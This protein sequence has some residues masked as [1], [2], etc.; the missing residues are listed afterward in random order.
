MPATLIEVFFINMKTS[1]ANFY[2][3]YYQRALLNVLRYVQDTK[4]AEDIVS[5]SMVKLWLTMEREEVASARALLYSILRSKTIDYLRHEQLRLS[6][7]RT[8]SERTKREMRLRTDLLQESP[9]MAELNQVYSMMECCLEKLPELTA[10]IFR[11]SRLRGISNKE[12][13]AELGVSEKSVE[14]HIHKVL[15]ILKKE[16]QDCILLGL[17]Y[18]LFT[19]I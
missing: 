10:T 8:L 11:M 14:Y 19:R 18:F 16:L 13:A 4:V 17:F 2:E 7:I 3:R 5:E 9:S 1:F 15:V 6:A 12:I